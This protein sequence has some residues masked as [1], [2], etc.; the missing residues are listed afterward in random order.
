VTVENTIKKEL[1][2]S[3]EDIEIQ[4]KSMGNDGGDVEISVDK[5]D[6][7]GICDRTKGRYRNHTWIGADKFWHDVLTEAIDE[8][9]IKPRTRSSRSGNTHL[10]SCYFTFDYY[11]DRDVKIIVRKILVTLD[12]AIMAERERQEVLE[13]STD[14]AQELICE[15]IS[16][17]IEDIE[18]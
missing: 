11:E 15:E 10:D 12:S 9:E 16:S 3:G 1:P 14:V 18:L 4:V 6:S 13:E 2:R 5:P 8:Y 17:R 7:S